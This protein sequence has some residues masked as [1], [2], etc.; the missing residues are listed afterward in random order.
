MRKPGL[1]S[2]NVIRANGKD[3]RA[4]DDSFTFETKDRGKVTMAR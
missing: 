4:A 1:G 2:V 3:D